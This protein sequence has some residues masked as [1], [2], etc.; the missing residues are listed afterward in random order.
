MPESRFREAAEITVGVAKA[1]GLAGIYFTI[2]G[3]DQLREKIKAEI[4]Y[5][6]TGE[7]PWRR[8]YEDLRGDPRE[9]SI[10]RYDI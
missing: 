5:Q 6:R 3:L 1:I 10:I 8:E 4:Y 2:A 7:W 9:P